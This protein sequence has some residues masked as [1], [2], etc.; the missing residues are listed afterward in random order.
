MKKKTNQF[1]RT[2]MTLLLAVLGSFMAVG[3]SFAAGGN[4]TK[5]N[6]GDND[7]PDAVKWEFNV[8]T[9]TLTISGT[10][11][12]LDFEQ[13]GEQ[14]WYPWGDD[15]TTVVIGEG[16][17]RIGNYA[18]QD[19]PLTS[20]MAQKTETASTRAD[21]GS[22]PIASALPE[23]LI[24]IGKYAL[25]NTHMTNL[26]LPS[27][28]QS[29]DK[30]ALAS[31][32]QLTTLTFL[33]TMSV[34]YLENDVFASCNNLTAIYVPETC[35]D[36]YKNPDCW[37]TYAELIKAIPEGGDE[38]TEVK[39]SEVLTVGS[40]SNA[41]GYLPSYPQSSYSTS[42]QIYTKDEIG[43]AGM[44]TSIAFY[45]YEMGK[46]RNYDIYLSHTTKEEFDSNTDWVTVSDANKVFSG[47]VTLGD[48]W[49]VIDFDTPFVYDGKQNLILTMDD[50]TGNSTGNNYSIGVYS[51]SGHQSL[52]YYKSTNLD[53]TQ[54]IE[55]EGDFH[56]SYSSD[57]KNGIQL[58]FETYPKPSK[59]EAVEVGDVSTQIQ[60]SLRGD[61]TAWNLRYRKV[62][63]EGEEEHA[64]TVV[65]NLTDRLKFI[66]GLTPLTKYEAQV[67]AIFPEDKLSDWTS[68]LVFTTACCPVEDQ[69]EIIYAV[70]SN[71]SSWY[72]YAI[73]F[74]DITDK[75]NPVEVAYVNPPSYSFTG[76]TLTLCCG[77]KY[78]V[79]WIYD[80]E[81]SNVN[82]QF[83]LA[84][85]FEPG[86]KFYSMARGT[87]PEETAELTTFVMD[88]TPY[89]TQMPQILNESGTTYNSATITFLSQTKTGQVVYSTEADFDPEKATPEDMDFEE[90]SQSEVPWDQ[91]NASITLKGLQPL[92][93]Y[94]VR[95][96]SVCTT[97]P[98]GV[99]RWSAPV[100]V[101]TSS[102]YDAPTQVI[103]E[104]VNSR[105][106]KLS[107][108]SRGSEQSHNLYYRKQAVGNPVDPSAI[109][110][111]GGGNGTG[112]ESG[113][114]GKGIHSSY[115]DRPFSNTLFVADV[116]A[117]SSFSFKAGNGKTAGGP[118]N[119]LY[120]MRPEN[121]TLTAGEVMKQFDM[122]CLNDA[123]RQARIYSA[124]SEINVIRQQLTDLDNRLNNGDITQEEYDIQKEKL[125]KELADNESELEYLN[126][127][128][129]DAELLQTMKELEQKISDINNQLNTLYNSLNLPILSEE[130]R[131]AT[132]LQI[133]KLESEAD[134]YF[135]H[136]NDLRAITT[137][138]ENTQKDG[139]SITREKESANA[140]TRGTDDDAYIFFIRHS[141]PNGVLLV[142][143]LTITPPEQQGEWI[144]IPNVSGNSYLLTGLE[145]GTTY[146][147]M[148]E[149]VYDGG[150]TGSRSPITVFTTLGEESEPLEG[151]FSVSK[152]KKV[153][154]AKGNL[155]Y[156]KDANWNDHWSLAEH[157]YDILGADNLESQEVNQYGNRFPSEDHLDLFCW[158]AGYSS[159]GTIHTYPDD[160]YYTGDF[161][162]WGT[163]TAFT[164]IYGFG[165]STMTKDEWTYL[166]SERENAATLK[167]F[168]T[169]N[170][171]K[172]LVLLPDEWNAPDGVIISEEM[173]AEQW[174]TIEKTGAV[175]L[176][177]AGTLTVNMEGSTVATV[178]DVNVVGSYW[179]STPSETDVNAFS[180]TFT[181]SEVKPAVDIYRRIGSAVRLV[182]ALPEPVKGDANNDGVVNVADVVEM[183]NARDNKPSAHFVMK[184]AD[185][186]GDGSITDADID[187][188]VKIIMG[189]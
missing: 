14:P 39:G 149:P 15:I 81:H 182:K 93:A 176:P 62:A 167:S 82:H 115:G 143:D 103:A 105:T 116:P 63:G 85:Y 35:V 12:M 189:K 123:D 132:E 144:V 118:V 59:L 78:K 4:S 164:D 17:T 26:T 139:F 122:Q 22:E 165:W 163:Q 102:R 135:A 70:N 125:E 130:Q 96:R 141:D 92:T 72:G 156:S 55:V 40:I 27:T 47:T 54:P 80:E 131:A 147:V 124:Q 172:G 43:K 129:S 128:P 87:A 79:N 52:Y 31:N 173:T 169:V 41:N 184:N 97:E 110:T 112:F 168:A 48:G 120:G 66:E 13:A 20:I 3:T 58:C 44:I 64:W 157:Q 104:P 65:N 6:C 186:D 183:I 30:F 154:F 153:S 145:P 73:Q 151:V 140:R 74:M 146:E 126:Q 175:F 137:N 171:V 106:E 9:G 7:A 100:K 185:F 107:W 67:Q 11:A 160:S 142:K 101:T 8:T 134:G 38:P 21:S 34:P 57:R 95:V 33:A 29:I 181:E 49:T 46:A 119:F 166:L 174:A 76:G 109:Q 23:G 25:Y 24:S 180:M 75:D 56:T 127:Q 187:A 158:S 113:S 50:N 159:N 42:Q 90:V 152:D 155:R 94:Y 117:G 16:V 138:A 84:L 5:G 114:W 170:G 178:N 91:P 162:E 179:S 161:K 121:V 1:A 68:P 86:D 150:T 10:G 89:C 133:K 69:A 19:F 88:C 45:N 61:A 28:L 32:S 36:D 108:G 71:Y 111:F 2:A 51:P 60:C 83:S 98:I 136:L 148:V 37:T 18:F 53:P 99:S 77:H 177:A 188:V